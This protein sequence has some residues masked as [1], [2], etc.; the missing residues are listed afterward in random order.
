M[1]RFALLAGALAACA[2]PPP[3]MVDMAADGDCPV[4]IYDN[5]GPCMTSNDCARGTACLGGQCVPIPACLLDCACSDGRTCQDERCEAPA[6]ALCGP[7]GDACTAALGVCRD[8]YCATRCDDA[9]TFCPRGFRCDIPQ[10]KSIGACVP[11]LVAGCAGCAVDGDCFNGE[12]CNPNNRRCVPAPTGPDARLEMEALDFL[13]DDGMGGKTRSRNLTWSLGF[14]SLPD[15]SFD[16]YAL[17]PG[18]CATAKST[19]DANAPF[20]IGPLRDAGALTLALPQK[21]VTFTPSPDP[22]PNFGVG[23][24]ETG[25]MVADWS[26]GAASWSAAGGP[27]VGA[28]TVAGT[29]A[30]DFTTMPDVLGQAPVQGDAIGGVALTLAPAPPAGVATFLVVSWNDV[31]G[32][33]VTALTQIAC[34]APDGATA[35]S[36]PGAQL[37]AAPRGTP[38]DLLVARAS[39]AKF[40][41]KGVS[42]GRAV[43][44]MQQVGAIVVAP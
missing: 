39:V 18:A 15:P 20:P 31:S 2:P 22:N 9:K 16:F 19:L 27:D 6:G 8:N 1:R 30:G 24:D 26:A 38:L 21:M 41:A 10:G 14:Y 23:Y 3:S 12:V 25:L 4:I 32:N 17:A 40:T 35:V 44:G 36:I 29:I 28:F 33:M 43:F 42:D 34:R 5:G 13:F 11:A 7:C 37:A